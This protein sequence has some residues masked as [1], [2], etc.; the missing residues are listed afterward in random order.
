MYVVFV[1]SVVRAIIFV[2]R[3]M[4]MIVVVVFVVSVVSVVIQKSRE[5]VVGVEI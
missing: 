1:G 2:V 4:A 5:I 3:V